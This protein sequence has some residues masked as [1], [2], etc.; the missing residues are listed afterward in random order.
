VTNGASIL[1]QP[2]SIAIDENTTTTLNVVA[3][4]LAP[5]SYQWYQGLTGDTTMPVGTN[6]ASFTTPALITDTSYWVKV[7][8]ATNTL[9]ADS[10]AAT[11][12]IN[13]TPPPAASPLQSGVVDTA[14][15]Y[16]AWKQHYFTET[17][18]ANTEI[19]GN[20]ADADGDGISN[21]NEYIFGTDP[22]QRDAAPL[23]IVAVEANQITL[24]FPTRQAA[25]IGY[26]GMTRHY[27]IESSHTLAN[28]DWQ[29][30]PSAADI[31]S[32]DQTYSTNISR[33]ENRAFFR[34]KSWLTH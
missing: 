25:G 12:T 4:G 21:E 9:G 23:L 6:S 29:V 28:D 7:T 30:V 17:T 10:A 5:F 14:T 11:V 26:E 19:S 24:S 3:G 8:N 33:T 22:M 18:L 27:A 20:A 13:P 2:A 32:N 1:T 31:K 16:D 15:L 34:I